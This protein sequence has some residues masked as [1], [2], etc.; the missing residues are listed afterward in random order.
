LPSQIAAARVQVDFVKL[1]FDRAERLHARNA[2]TQTAL[3]DARSKF[4]LAEAALQTALE[5][6]ALLGAPIFEAVRKDV[7][8]VRVPIYAG[9]VEQINRSAA[10]RVNSLGR[11][12]DAARTARPIDI[13]FSG[14]TASAVV[15]LYYELNNAESSWLPGQ[16]VT[17]A[18]PI[19]VEM[20][21]LVAPAASVIYDFQGGAWV[22]ERTGPEKFTRRRVE[23]GRASDASVV[24][25]RGVR[26]GAALVTAGTAELFGTEFGSGK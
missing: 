24:L 26:P 20:D 6:R 7:L 9:D 8:W 17:V 10:A 14:A 12:N 23:V 4:Q 1:A 22:Y 5:R 3:D 18:V 11:R 21:A 2:G 13:P 16:K 15:D 25:R 19:D